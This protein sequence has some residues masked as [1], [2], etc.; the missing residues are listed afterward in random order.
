M[1]KNSLLA[2][3][4]TS[5]FATVIALPHRTDAMTFGDRSGL[6]S[7]A[8][9]LDVVKPEQV[10]WCGWFGCRVGYYR[11]WPYYASWWPI[12]RSVAGFADLRVC[13]DQ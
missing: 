3:L 6:R 12:S 1:R 10:R 5:I 7:A 8:N 4:A 2:T 13:A 9:K 11:P